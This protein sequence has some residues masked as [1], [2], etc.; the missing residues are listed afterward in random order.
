MSPHL[1]SSAADEL[2]ALQVAQ[3]KHDE[4]YHREIARLTVHARLN[5]MAL[6]FS[7]YVGQLAKA[8]RDGDKLLVRRTVTDSF[9]IG[10]SCANILNIRLSAAIQTARDA[11]SL[12]ELGKILL[13]QSDSAGNA[14]GDWLLLTYAIEAGQ[15]ARACEKLDH[16]EAYPFREKIAEAVVAICKTSVMAATVSEFDLR[17]AIKERFDEIETLYLFHNAL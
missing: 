13:R 3:L 17:S 11:A 4:F 9:V 7:K 15:M 5:H 2:F 1:H 6:H 8:V 14:R 16:L 10:L 12:S